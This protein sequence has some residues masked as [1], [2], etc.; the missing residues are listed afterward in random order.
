MAG[1]RLHRDGD[2]NVERGAVLVTRF[3]RGVVWVV[4]ALLV[5]TLVAT[6]LV[7]ATA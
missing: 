7:D 5:F 3:R 4:V 2:R 1:P 6:L